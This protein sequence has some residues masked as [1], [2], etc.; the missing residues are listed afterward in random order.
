MKVKIEKFNGELPDYLTVG[1]VYEVIYGCGINVD[2]VGDDGF[3]VFI[4]INDCGYLN[5]GSWEIV[6]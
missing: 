2:I 3:L 1:K 6:E 5:G 4:N